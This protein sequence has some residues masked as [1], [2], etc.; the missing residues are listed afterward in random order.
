MERLTS[1]ESISFSGPGVTSNGLARFANLTTSSDRP[2]LI[3]TFNVHLPEK[4]FGAMDN[5]ETLVLDALCS[6]GADVRFTLSKEH[7]MQLATLPNLRVLVIRGYRISDDDAVILAN[8][9]K[10]KYL[11]LRHTSVSENA[12]GKLETS[13]SHCRI[14]NRD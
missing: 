12:L 9:S 10:L 6:S 13:L 3:H 2:R 11:G 7:K 4:F 5:V 14:I 1:L 8:C